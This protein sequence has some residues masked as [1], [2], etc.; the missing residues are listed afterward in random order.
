MYFF[1]CTKIN[2]VKNYFSNK[3]L[4]VNLETIFVILENKAPETGANNK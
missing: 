1:L 3:F 4:T 2:T